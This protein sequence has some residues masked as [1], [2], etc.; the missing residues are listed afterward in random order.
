MFVANELVGLL[1][2]EKKTQKE[3]DINNNKETEAKKKHFQD[4]II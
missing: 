4:V 1:Y 3:K 2:T